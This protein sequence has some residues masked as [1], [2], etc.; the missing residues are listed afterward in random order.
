MM[1]KQSDNADVETRLRERATMLI[2]Y[3]ML[4][5]G[6]SYIELSEKLAEIGVEDSPRNLSNKVRRGN[7]G[8]VTLLQI[9]EVLEIDEINLRAIN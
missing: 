5:K 8:V 1:E 2:R 9:M 3:M 7:F 4:T 6:V